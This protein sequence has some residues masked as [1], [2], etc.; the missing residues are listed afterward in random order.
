MAWKHSGK[1]TAFDYTGL[2][3][4]TAQA[5]GIACD[6]IS[7]KSARIFITQ[8]ALAML[9]NLNHFDQRKVV[10][11]IAHVCNN[12]GSCS[13]IKHSKLPF[14][15]LWR[16]KEQFQSYH[17][18]ID[19]K[20]AA[21]GR[22]VIHDIYFDTDVT[23]A[24]TRHSLERNMLYT[25]KRIGGRFDGAFDGE[26]LKNTKAAWGRP[27]PTPQVR[28]LH[29][30]V[31]GM[32]NDLLKANWLMGT[33]L[34]V[35]YPED[36][37]KTYTLF[38]NPT[39]RMFYDVVECVFDKR[40]GTKSQNAQHLAAL[41]QQTQQKGQKTKWVVHS[42]GAIIFSAALEEYRKSYTSALTCHQVV[43][44]SPGAW[45]PR[46]KQAATALGMTVVN[47]RSNPF[48]IVPN[49]AGTNDLSPSSL[50]RSLK[51]MGLTF[52][53]SETT[54]PH[55]LPFLGLES[56]HAQLRFA[57]NHRRANDVLKYMGKHT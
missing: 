19:Y 49:L 25:V 45:L 32:Q 24:K 6:P 55:T 20:I 41:F 51:F 44:H 39:D 4:E 21:D 50:V 30:A 18:L 22:V 35:A 54:S 46:L 10:K 12:P 38:H 13:S 29:A 17:Y 7:L 57:G 3:A 5:Y 36:D 23:G 14:K 27:E 53:G 33:H 42:Q 8:Q 48:D 9:A 28:T 2:D 34:D 43:V 31:N 26:D 15:R 37:F 16:S 56:Y 47:E 11:E 1:T 52:L 40:Q